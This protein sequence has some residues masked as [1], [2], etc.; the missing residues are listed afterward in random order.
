METKIEIKQMPDFRVI[1]VRHTGE[2]HGI[3][4]AYEK[5]SRWSGPRGLMNEGMKTM[6]V[7]HD[8]PAVTSIENLRQSACIVVDED[9]KVEGD[10][11]RMVVNGGKF[12]VGRFTIGIDGFE[13]AWNTMCN[14]LIDSGYEP[15]DG[16]HYELYHEERGQYPDIT[17]VL[18]I[19]IP[20]KAL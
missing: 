10:V 19:C 13:K 9:V 20:L 4:K 7:Y 15:S 2:F 1:Y 16:N 18:D 14:W 12:A 5:L 6:T 3:S 11:G 8:D 17:F